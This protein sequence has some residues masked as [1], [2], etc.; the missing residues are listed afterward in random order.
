MAGSACKKRDRMY[1]AYRGKK[2]VGFREAGIYE[3]NKQAS[4]GEG[5]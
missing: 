3:T 2:H 4:N 5:W 1:A